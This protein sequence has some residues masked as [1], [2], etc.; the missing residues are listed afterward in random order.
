[1]SA[2]ATGLPIMAAIIT[3]ITRRIISLMACTACM[4]MADAVMVM[5]MVMTAVM[6][7]MAE[8]ITAPVAPGF[9]ARA[10]LAPMAARRAVFMAE[11]PI[12]A[13]RITPAAPISV[14]AMA[15]AMAP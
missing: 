10:A 2:P 4:G 11:R 5:G 12:S 3:A 14:V 1:M 9:T 15:E 6:A 13:G 8:F 7:A